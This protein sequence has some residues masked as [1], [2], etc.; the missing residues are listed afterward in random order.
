MPE[1]VAAR[2]KRRLKHLKYRSTRR[3]RAVNPEMCGC[4]T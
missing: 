2:E 1:T 3:E 4:V